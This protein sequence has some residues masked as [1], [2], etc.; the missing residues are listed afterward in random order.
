MFSHPS[1]VNLSRE[2]GQGKKGGVGVGGKL[3]CELYTLTLRNKR[4]RRR[5]REKNRKGTQGRKGSGWIRETLVARGPHLLL[6][7]DKLEG[8]MAHNPSREDYIDGE[9]LDTRFPCE[10][11]LFLEGAVQLGIRGALAPS[12]GACGSEV[13]LER[14]ERLN[15][16][17]LPFSSSS[18]L[19]TTPPS[20]PPVPAQRSWSLIP[21]AAAAAAKSVVSIEVRQLFLGRGERDT[22]TR[23]RTQL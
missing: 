1:E 10:K 7:T 9:S 16:P 3:L 13:L 21:P 6:R 2:E 5:E 4:E 19:T 12:A 23:S 11:M 17:F 22:H 18:A 8:V 20:R 14:K 15:P